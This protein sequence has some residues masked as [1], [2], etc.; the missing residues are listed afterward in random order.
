MATFMP[1]AQAVSENLN[2]GDTAA[3][4]GFTHL[5]PTPRRMRRSARDFAT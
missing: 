3:F 2:D 5:I 4:E 1:L